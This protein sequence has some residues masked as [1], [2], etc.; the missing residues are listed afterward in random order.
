MF[1]LVKPVYAEISYSSMTED[2]LQSYLQMKSER[3]KKKQIVDIARTLITILAIFFAIIYSVKKNKDLKKYSLIVI[4]MTIAFIIFTNYENN[5]LVS[6]EL[7]ALS[8]QLFEELILAIFI[9][10]GYLLGICVKN[11]IQRSLL[12]TI[13]LISFILLFCG[14]IN[15]RQFAYKYNWGIIYTNISVTILFK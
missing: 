14:G 13:P 11:N 15:R 8:G 7:A 6:H 1:C 2:E 4:T 12:T 9:L 5:N 10:V 3:A